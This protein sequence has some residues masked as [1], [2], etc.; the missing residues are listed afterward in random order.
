MNYTTKKILLAIAM[1]MLLIMRVASAQI[2]E[3]QTHNYFTVY[4]TMG[5]IKSNTA[6]IIRYMSS[7][8]N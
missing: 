3:E 1:C 4:P 7:K 5:P 2:S 8:S 6:A